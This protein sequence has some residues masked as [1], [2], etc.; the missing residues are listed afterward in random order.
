[1]ANGLEVLDALARQPYDVVFMDVQM[2]EMDGLEASRRIRAAGQD[3]PQ[4]RIVAMTAHALDEARQQCLDA[5]M[6]DYISKPVR[7]DELAAAL[8][9]CAAALSSGDPGQESVG[10]GKQG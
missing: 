6:D 7:L 3:L 9:R 8:H 1:V 10:Q 4:P 2:P 5:G